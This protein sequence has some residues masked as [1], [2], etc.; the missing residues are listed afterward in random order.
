M[1]SFLVV[2]NLAVVSG[3]CDAGNTISEDANLGQVNLV[4]EGLS[5]HDPTNCPGGIGLR[6]L[7]S[8]WA[9]L[10]I[11]KTYT[12]QFDV[13]TCQV[14]WQR[15]AYAYIDFN[16]NGTYDSNELLGQVS[17]DN[18]AAPFPV[19]FTFTV[20]SQLSVPG[21][22]RMRVF[23]VESGFTANPCLTFSYGQVKEFSINITRGPGKSCCL[24]TTY[25]SVSR[26]TAGTQVETITKYQNMAL[27]AYLEKSEIRGQSG[28]S[29]LLCLSSTQLCYSFTA[30]TCQ[31]YAFLFPTQ[32]CPGSASSKFAY[33]SETLLVP[34]LWVSLYS[35]TG[36]TMTTTALSA[37]EWC[38]VTTLLP[39]TVYLSWSLAVP[40]AS[41]FAIPAICASPK[42]SVLPASAISFR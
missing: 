26:V 37:S 12:L 17:V 35:Q 10:A 16:N 7:T 11:E 40:P 30:T 38:A 32:E 25:S 15:L 19:S 3:Y 13:T 23:V 24:P 20:S 9:T 6:D 2:L 28:F 41:T 39:S 42:D 22:T 36:M 14:G 29:G 8:Q 27:Q 34:G 4:G 31:K 1:Y 21:L 18:R 5:I 33:E